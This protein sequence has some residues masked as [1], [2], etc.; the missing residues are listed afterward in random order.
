MVGYCH[1]EKPTYLFGSERRKADVLD[2][3]AVCREAM[4]DVVSR[5][6]LQNRR[7]H[8]NSNRI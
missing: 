3:T 7:Y 5:P 4:S 1:Q 6:M 8:F 2:V